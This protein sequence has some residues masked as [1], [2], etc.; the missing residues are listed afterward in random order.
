MPYPLTW[1]LERHDD[2]VGDSERMRTVAAP[3][4]IPAAVQAL[5]LNAARRH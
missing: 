5:A 2:F 4:E 1:A 3:A